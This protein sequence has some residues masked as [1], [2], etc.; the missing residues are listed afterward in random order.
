MPP[1]PSV[2][3]SSAKCWRVEHADAEDTI[4]RTMDSR[5]R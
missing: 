1:N 5:E 4:Q 2:S 3:I